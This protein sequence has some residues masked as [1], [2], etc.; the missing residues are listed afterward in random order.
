[1][2]YQ[3]RLCVLL[4]LIITLFSL[5]FSYLLYYFFGLAV[6][7][8]FYYSEQFGHVQMRKLHPLVFSYAKPVLSSLVRFYA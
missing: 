2:F 6:G 3:R 5:L 8:Y 1:M 4:L 7:D